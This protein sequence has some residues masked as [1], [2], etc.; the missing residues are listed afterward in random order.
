MKQ[1]AG[2]LF[3]LSRYM[4]KLPGAAASFKPS[5]Q[6]SLILRVRIVD[7]PGMLGKLTSVIGKA[8]GS[9]GTIELVSTNDQTLVRDIVVNA[10][11]EAQAGK[12]LKAVR[13]LSFVEVVSVLDQTFLLHRG[14]KIEVQPTR[15]IHTCEE[16][17][18][19]YTP[20]VGR[21][22]TA[23]HERPEAVW[24]Y[25]IKGNTVAVVTDGSA[26]LGLGNLGP[27]ASLPVM[28][29]KAVLFKA[30]AGINA[31]PIC[32]KTQNVD[33]IVATVERIAPAFG[34]VNLEDISAP[35]CFEIERELKKRLDIPVMHDD[36]HGTAVVVLAGLLNALRLVGKRLASV[37]IIVSGAGAAAVGVSSLLLEAGARD[38]VICDREGAIYEG[39]GEN[40]NPMK[41]CLARKTNAR[42]FK[43][44]I[45]G[46]LRGADVFLGL[47]MPGAVTP[48]E[49]KRMGRDSIIFA[50]A[51]PTP[52]VMPEEVPFARVVATGRSDYPNQIN[53]ALAFPGVFK[54]AMEARARTI[55]DAMLIAAAKAIA[56]SVPPASLGSRSIVPSIFD[57][58]VCPAVA[59]AV[60]E[61]AGRSRLSRINGHHASA[62]VAGRALS[63][64]RFS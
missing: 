34:G 26:V 46:A 53:N 25:T 29:G 55:T 20:G 15:P 57:E 12:V 22:S 21:V 39:R 64:A 51:N 54:G 23:I 58:A 35:R 27:E 63:G 28:E 16:L 36:Q 47:S 30:F 31:F 38:I 8:G 1:A 11:S 3:P 17:S 37:R 32:L 44:P 9:L 56:E 50:M 5:S 48:A 42:R 49:L 13:R 61:A 14:G 2:F 6:F 40:M 4:G 59:R 60:A 62:V 19:I 10:A 52:E 43:G 41:V 7:R 18:M 24:D 33:E 45:G